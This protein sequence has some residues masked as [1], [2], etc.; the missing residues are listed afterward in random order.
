MDW[1]MFFI[2]SIL[3]ISPTILIRLLYFKQ[4]GLIINTI[5]DR[6]YV[7]G[8]ELLLTL[9]T[10][11]VVYIVVAT[12]L[13]VYTVL[14]NYWDLRIYAQIHQFVS[15]LLMTKDFHV[16]FR[17]GYNLCW[18]LLMLLWYSTWRYLFPREYLKDL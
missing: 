10:W 18:I 5:A 9:K 3:A 11:L 7:S 14:H 1:G 13:W 15:N 8:K 4:Q 6:E 16:P 12:P 2:A 17:V